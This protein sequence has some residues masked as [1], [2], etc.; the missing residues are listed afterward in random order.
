[1]EFSWPAPH[2]LTLLPEF[3]TALAIGLMIG[4]ERER[5][6]NSKA[7]L[8]TFAIVA[9]S[10]A[11][12][13][14]IANS[15][16]TPELIAVGLGA[17]TLT[18]IAAYFHEDGA[19][20]SD[21]GATT[22]AAAIL[23]Y[24][25]AVMVLS[26]WLHLPVIL[27][28]A[29]TALLYFKA[30]L[31][32]FARSLERRDLISILQFALVAFIVLPL[33][34]DTD[35]GI[36]GA[37][38]PRQVWWM[39][40]LISGVS[41]AGYVTLRLGGGKIGAVLLGFLGGLVSSTATTLAYSRHGKN[42]DGFATLG[43]TVILTA[44]LVVLVRLTV[45]AAV[46]APAVLPVLTPILGTGFLAG[47][48]V[49]AI[50]SKRYGESPPIEM[51]QLANP[52]E[53]GPALGFAALYGL[54][55]ILAAWLSEIIGTRGVYAIAAVSGLLD[56]DAITLSSF[57]LADVGSLTAHQASI[58]VAIAV[59]ANIAFKLGVVR[60]AGGPSMFRRCLPGLAAVLVGITAAL[61]VVV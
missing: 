28:I 17:T 51:P 38:N 43:V 52:A 22:I 32:G 6:S 23:C 5:H 1:M 54:V 45:F 20:D 56:V 19:Q 37:I 9:M 39:V 16:G 30:E 40:V 36:Y 11:A 21:R 49:F 61:A 57:R 55:L 18:L 7:G 42:G 33:L 13:A 27:A 59:S 60:A 44:N 41:L 53:L 25:L 35:M 31:G 46:V 47:A 24:L 29:A 2:G 48:A 3:A 10:G 14:A 50:F 34:P 15:S 8:R 4:L 26:G 58:A 12:A